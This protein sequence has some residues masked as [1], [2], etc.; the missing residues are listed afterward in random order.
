MKKVGGILLLL[1]FHILGAQEIRIE[2]QNWWVGFKNQQLQLLVYAPNISETTPEINY[3]GVVVEKVNRADSP[4]YLFLDLQIKENCRPG[5]FFI[6]FVSKKGKKKQVAYELKKR[7]K[8][9]EEYIGFNP[10]DVIYLITPDRFA[11]GNDKNDVVS[12]LKETKIDRKDDYARHGGDIQ[13]MSEHLDYIKNMGF[14]AIWPSPLLINDAPKYSYHGYA[15]TDFYEVDP[16][17]GTMEEYKKFAQKVKNNGMKL[18]MDQV[19]NHCGINHW[20]I[21]DLP[22]KDWLNFQ[23]EFEQGNPIMT[24]HARTTHQDLYASKFDKKR[25]TGGWFVSEMPDLNQRNPYLA[26]YIIQNSIWWIETLQLGGIRQDTSPYPY[27]D[28]MAQWTQEIMTEYPNFSIVGEEWSTNPLLV[29]YWQ[30]GKINKDGYQAYFT[31]GMDFPMQKKIVEALTEPESWDKG[32]VKIYEGLANDFHYADAHNLLAFLDN[33][34]MDRVYTQLGEDPVK[35]KMAL[36]WLLCLPR[37]PQIYYGTEIGMENSRKPGD[38]GLIRSDFPGGWEQDKIN[39]FTQENL[40]QNQKELQSFLK[41]VLN[42][43]KNS[44]AITEGETIHFKPEK[45]IYFLFRKQGKEIVICI[46]NKNEEPVEVDLGRFKEIGLKGRKMKNLINE[47]EIL[48]G[49]SL[50]LNEKGITILVSE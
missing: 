10:S 46:L 50:K 28:F 5:H 11:N 2:P 34:D 41:K 31:A 35:M 33:H 12:G 15:M 45:G 36:G 27:E 18:I 30:R 19:A 29:A 8:K 40:S 1:L 49:D 23:K 22:F 24:N 17:F 48:W 32:L 6:D 39:A 9:S 7:Q 38:H 4:N 37:I 25:M 13:G 20:W 42:Y 47:K 26:N 43:R 16:R 21:K 3:E 44:K 14:T